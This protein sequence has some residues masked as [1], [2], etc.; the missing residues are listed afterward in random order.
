MMRVLFVDDEQAVLDGLS[1][2]L[3]RQRRVW[4]MDF[5]CGPEPALQQLGEHPYDVVVT[6]M[7]MPGMDGAA[8]LRV[9]KE[10][11]PAAARIV[12]SGHS[13]RAMVMRALAVAQQFVSKP[14]EADQL[15]Q[16]IERA[17]ALQAT[18]G[19]PEIRRVVGA[20][21][22]LPTVPALYVELTQAMEESTTDV[23]DIAR[24]V[25]RDPAMSA[26]LL[27]LANSAFF[28]RARTL[29]STSQAVAYL[30][31]EI[32]RSLALSVGVF[33]AAGALSVAGF[34]LDAEQQ[35]ALETALRARALAPE[36]LADEAFTGGL[37]HDVGV[38]ALALG[39][40]RELEGMLAEARVA[41]RPMHEVE[42]AA[43]G[44]SHAEVGAYLLGMW[45]LPSPIVEATALH[46][47]TEGLTEL[48]QI[49]QRAD[50]DAASAVDGS[51]G[52][53]SEVGRDR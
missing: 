11:Q 4:Q 46:H 22:R 39:V 40:P 36:A 31:V 18:L 41:R 16:V 43:L 10:R 29:S 42:R 32:V 37:V 52:A 9:V 21:D 26:K 23:K 7:R 20:I 35:H 50:H 45:G 48:A 14:C 8:L 47:A 49:V 53:C 30:G 1:L 34:A 12:L 3:R 51:R 6:D 25:E 2:L 15:R 33:G 17:A 28:G 24:I 38:L 19:A 13:E 5:A 27:Q 44:V